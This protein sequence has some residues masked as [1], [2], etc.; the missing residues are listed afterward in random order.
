LS[1]KTQNAAVS[2]PIHPLSTGQSVNPA[3]PRAGPKLAPPGLFGK[4]KAVQGWDARDRFLTHY[5]ESPP[6]RVTL[7]EACGRKVYESLKERR[8]ASNKKLPPASVAELLPDYGTAALHHHDLDHLPRKTKNC[9]DKWSKKKPRHGGGAGLLRVPSG[10]P[11][12]GEGKP[13][14]GGL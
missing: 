11:C 6:V 4:K 9:L 13:I 12:D 8:L 10:G 1:P 14:T 2:A 7:G 3:R 5:H